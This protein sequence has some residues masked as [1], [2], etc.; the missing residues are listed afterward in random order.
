MGRSSIGRP[1]PTLVRAHRT[2][3]RAC[4]R[5]HP[6]RRSLASSAG[7]TLI[8]VVVSALLLAVIVVGTLT[9]INSANRATSLDRA[10]SQADSLAQQ[11]ED[12]L[13]SE[14][15]NKLSELSETHE[16]V[17]HEVDAG[18]TTY[19]ISS[20]AKYI[21]DY[22]GHVELHLAPRKKPTTSRRPPR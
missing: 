14:P 20:T 22:D 11:D 10:R 8:E 12:H 5:L 7:D 19:T 17:L 1:A 4:G 21:A 18:G 13:R 9:G 2:L 15:I 3:A 6:A 16:A